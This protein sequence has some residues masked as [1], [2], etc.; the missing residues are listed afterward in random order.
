MMV[1]MCLLCAWSVFGGIFWTRG[2]CV[3]A[4]HTHTPRVQNL[5]LLHTLMMLVLSYYP[6]FILN[7]NKLSVVSHCRYFNVWTETF[8][9]C[10]M[11][12][13]SYP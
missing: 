12:Y 2:V 11:C 7:G 5:Y 8:R 6:T 9:M 13:G 4:M 1:Q 10:Q 3:C